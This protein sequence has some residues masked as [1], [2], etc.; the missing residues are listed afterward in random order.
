M[1]LTNEG[2]FKSAFKKA[3]ANMEKLRTMVNTGI[4]IIWNMKDYAGR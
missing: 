4:L 3:N 1:E 2:K